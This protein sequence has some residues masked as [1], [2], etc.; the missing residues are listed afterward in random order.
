[1]LW[2]SLPLFCSS[3]DKIILF[4]VLLHQNEQSWESLFPYNFLWDQNS[5]ELVPIDAI[6]CRINILFAVIENLKNVLPIY[7]NVLQYFHI[8]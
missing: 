1:M 4:G 7:Q 3:F 5:T 6:A 8:N 2:L